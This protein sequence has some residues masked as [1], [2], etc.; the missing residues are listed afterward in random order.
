MRNSIRPTM[1]VVFGLLIFLGA[2]VLLVPSKAGFTQEASHV[3]PSEMSETEDS[4][5][6]EAYVSEVIISAPWGEKNLVYGGEESPPGEFGYATD[7]ERFIG[8]SCFAVAPNGDI[9]IADQLNNRMQRFDSQGRFMSTTPMP[10]SPVDICIDQNDNLYLLRYGWKPEELGDR[11]GTV[12]AV[13]KCDQKGDILR[14]YP[15]FTGVG[16]TANF[17]LCDKFGRVFYTYPWSGEK[18]GFYQVGTAEKVFSF[19]E[20]KSSAKNG[21]LGLNSA[22]LKGNLFFQPSAML[23]KFGHGPLFTVTFAGDTLKPGYPIRGGVFG[24]DANLNVYTNSG[25]KYDLNGNLVAS[26]GCEC[27]KPY[28]QVSGFG[29][30]RSRTLDEEGNLYVLCFSESEKEGIR[31]IRCYKQE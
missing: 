23:T 1:M 27:E 7:D 14:T 21:W 31:V 3:K 29:G 19:A 25:S 28:L 11:P 16:A 5:A 2:R 10:I 6:Q 9:Y 22:A 13:L 18:S 4:L 26:W 17:V 8:P 15:V 24:C 30:S 20:Q 12:G